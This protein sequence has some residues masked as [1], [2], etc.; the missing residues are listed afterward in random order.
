[1]YST[2][3]TI[4]FFNPFKTKPFAAEKNSRSSI[5]LK[6][7]VTS[8][9]P[10]GTGIGTKLNPSDQ[11][12]LQ[13][14]MSHGA[15]SK[16]E[17]EDIMKETVVRFQKT[18]TKNSRARSKSTEK[19]K[20]SSSSK[21]GRGRRNSRAALDDALVDEEEED[22]DGNLNNTTMST[23]TSSSS[24]IEIE[25]YKQ[26]LKRLNKALDFFDLSIRGYR[27]DKTDII[28]VVCTK[29]DDISKFFGSNIKDHEKE[30][31][32]KFW[33]LLQNQKINV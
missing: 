18:N 21:G 3:F 33:E 9:G 2:S 12:L 20:G 26:L 22:N 19:A 31:F 15:I 30:Y 23:S 28:G 16:E 25:N 13:Y 27:H 7:P 32:Q 17:L 8:I 24:P 14:I 5:S 6:M 4:H 1:M 10:T 29:S 11:Y